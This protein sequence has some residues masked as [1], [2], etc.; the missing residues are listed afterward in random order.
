MAY[1]RRRGEVLLFGG[2]HENHEQ[3]DDT[4]VWKGPTYRCNV[5]MPGDLNCDGVVDIDDRK[6][7]DAGHGTPACAPDDTRDL[8]GD[9]HITFADKTALEALC[10]FADCARYPGDKDRD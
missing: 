6:I 4:W 10:T 5:M 9:G 1:D 3:T 8:D 2:A 7:V